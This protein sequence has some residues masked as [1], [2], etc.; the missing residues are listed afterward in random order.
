VDTLNLRDSIFNLYWKTILEISDS[1]DLLSK[2]NLNL[3]LITFSRQLFEVARIL[4]ILTIQP[5]LS[6]ACLLEQRKC[7]Y[8]KL[9]ASNLAPDDQKGYI[10]SVLIPEIKQLEQG[11]IDKKI[12]MEDWVEQKRIWNEKNKDSSFYNKL[13]EAT[14]LEINYLIVHYMQTS[15]NSKKI[16]TNTGWDENERLISTKKV[17]DHW[18]KKCETTIKTVLND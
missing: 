10:E 13:S 11:M 6:L 14:H 9:E 17:F 1:A 2:N 16:D 15:S 18:L 8:K 4:E 5:D 7:E 3:S 12:A